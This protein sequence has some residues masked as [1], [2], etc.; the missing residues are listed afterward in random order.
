MHDDGQAIEV[1]EDPKIPAFEDIDMT[2]PPRKVNFTQRD[3]LGVC[4]CAEI[5]QQE[6]AGSEQLIVSRATV[7]AC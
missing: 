1:I 4:R 7:T 3:F 6:S 2:V 5:S